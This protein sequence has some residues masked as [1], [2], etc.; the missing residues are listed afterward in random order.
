[1]A[2]R[3]DLIVVGGGVIGSAIAEAVRHDLGRICLVERSR[4]RCGSATVAAAGGINPHLGDGENE[5]IAGL[6]QRSR[7]LYPAWVERIAAEAGLPLTPRS[8]GLLQVAVDEQEHRR[9]TDHVLPGLR[10]RGIQV[11]TL[12]A[13]AAREREPLLGPEVVG[14]LEQPHDLAIDP[15]AL[16]GAL[17]T[18]LESDRGVDLRIGEVRSVTAS[19]GHAEVSLEDGTRLMADK[20]VVAAGHQSGALLGMLPEDV[21]QPV[22]GQ[23]LD[24]SVPPGHGLGIQCDALLTVDGEEHVVYASPYAEG[25]V[26]VGVTFEKGETDTKCMPWARD[27]ILANLR[28][29]LPALAELG[30]RE[31]TPRAGIR[32]A[33]RDEAPLIGRLDEAG[34]ILVASGHNGLGIT[35]APRTAELLRLIIAGSAPT[36]QDLRDLAFS[37]PRRF[38]RA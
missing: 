2:P 3:Y 18:V 28:R 1:M 34:R 23:L 17:D 29:V 8:V 25:H 14:A 24:L 33:T 37:D 12:D 32:P 6:A 11:V 35:L 7:D 36:A 21:F 5:G 9:L 10:R 30:A 13:A 38:L 16:N 4:E 19:S 22:K 15:R 27:E 20:V 31:A 26:A